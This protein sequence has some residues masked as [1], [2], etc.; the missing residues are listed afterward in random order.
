[1]A[2]GAMPQTIVL[3]SPPHEVV[4]SPETG[5]SLL[6]FSTTLP[7]GGTW[8]WLRPAADDAD[9]AL[10]MACFPM[11][12]FCNR[13]ADAR[14]S[15]GGRD[16][17]LVPNFPPEPHAI[18]GLGWQSP[19]DVT[20]AEEAKAVLQFDHTGRGWP[21][22][23]TAT[24]TV[25]LSDDGLAIELAV[26]NRA[27]EAM[28]SGLG[29]HPYFARN[30]AVAV[31]ALAQELWFND[32]RNL[33]FARVSKDPLLDALKHG[34]PLPSGYDNQISGWTG[35]AD[36]AWQG[37]PYRL[38]L[39]TSPALSRAV[40]YSPA[41][42]PFFCFEPVTHAWNALGASPKRHAERGVAALA[43]GET[44]SLTMSLSVSSS[45]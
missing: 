32:A 2:K 4:V 38:T 21:W 40:V 22:P 31:T 44:Q 28:P 9:S 10:E 34:G 42:E 6:R 25:T 7:G 1:M 27:K 39:S 13:I 37:T 23:F 18:H 15:Y 33:P 16:V 12:P 29:L 8:H 5:G 17:T 43:P 20:D 26:R 35:R 45:G 11:V 36:I 30:G 3:R 41:G 24:Q 14:F 19:W